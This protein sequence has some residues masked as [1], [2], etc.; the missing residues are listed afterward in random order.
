MQA[1]N[2]DQVWVSCH[3]ES[4]HDVE[5]QGKIMYYP[6]PGF[7]NYF[8]PYKHTTGYMSPLVAVQFTSPK[9]KYIVRLSL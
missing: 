3:G 8:Y 7:P 4:P 5:N 2:R 1:Y 6:S 9:R